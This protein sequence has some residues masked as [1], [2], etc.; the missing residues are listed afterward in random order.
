MTGLKD[1]KIG[2]LLMNTPKI[3][4]IV[5]VYNVEKYIHRCIDSLLAQTFTDFEIILVD[6]GSY[7]NSGKICDEYAV[8]DRRIKVLHKENGG[9]ASA[10]QT[11]TDAVKGEYVIH[12]D[13][14]DWVS[15]E[16]LK[17]LYTKAK[18]TDADVIICDY[19]LA[20]V[21][22]C[23]YVSQ[24]PSLLTAE[25]VLCDMFHGLHGS[26]WN[27]LV[28]QTCYTKYGLHF[29]PNVNFCED[30]LIWVQLFR[31]KEI[32]IS[33]L[34]K[35]FYFYFQGNSE[36]ITH[37]LTPQIILTTYKYHAFLENLMPSELKYIVKRTKMQFDLLLWKK[38]MLCNKEILSKG[39]SIS[40]IMQCPYGIVEK[41]CYFFVV[42]NM[43]ILA[44]FI[45]YI[46][47][48]WR[49]IKRRTGGIFKNINF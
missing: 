4:V 3:S 35:A 16:M 6:D 21:N 38:K 10:R 26:L 29:I 40:D 32:K 46:Q 1:Y 30:V 25:S 20:N 43:P 8:I 23:R 18:E 7:D 22:D 36:S 41:T 33:Y 34:N 24:R 44:R 42:L 37:S 17:E 13:P 45:L 28:K 2:D 31:H 49:I 39:Y 11:G 12:A 15:S 47:S 19:Y 5:P 48:V 27:K 9:V 14:D